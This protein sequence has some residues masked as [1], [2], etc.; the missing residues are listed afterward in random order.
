MSVCAVKN[1]SNHQRNNKGIMFFT[2]PRNDPVGSEWLRR[3]KIQR[4]DDLPKKIVLCETHFSGEMFDKSVD[5]QIKLLKGML[6]FK[7]YLL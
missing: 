3:I 2:L 4:K 6:F 7:Y 5:L 1:C